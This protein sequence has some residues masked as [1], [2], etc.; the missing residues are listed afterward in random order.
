MWLQWFDTAGKVKGGIQPIKT[1]ASKS[2]GMA[3]YVSEAGGYTGTALKP[4]E[5]ESFGLSCE[6]AQGKDDWRVETE[7]KA[8]MEMAVKTVCVGGANAT[9]YQR[10]WQ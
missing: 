6:D 10:F 5:Y 1:S 2:L 7:K 4:F 3:V 8:D 9:G